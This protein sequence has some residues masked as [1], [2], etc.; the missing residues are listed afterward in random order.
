M[1]TRPKI[2]FFT[3]YLASL[4]L[5]KGPPKASQE[6]Q[7]K[8]ALRRVVDLPSPQTKK[9][10]LFLFCL[11]RPTKARQ[12]HQSVEDVNKSEK[13]DEMEEEE[14]A[15]KEKR[16]FRSAGPATNRTQPDRTAPTPHFR[17]VRDSTIRLFLFGD[18]YTKTTNSVR[19]RAG[20]GRKRRR[21]FCLFSS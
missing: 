2:Q 18:F 3:I 8:H 21:Y 19:D 7:S 13:R 6:G 5:I 12:G 20:R 17:R 9:R 10:P 16:K 11:R 1:A 4:A 15:R 14:E